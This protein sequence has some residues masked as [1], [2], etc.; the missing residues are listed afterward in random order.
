MSAR[1]KLN[2]AYFNGAL[3]S[4]AAIGWLSGSWAV[5]LAVLAAAVACAVYGGEIRPTRRRR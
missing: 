4:S 5:F 2:G 3:L 1:T